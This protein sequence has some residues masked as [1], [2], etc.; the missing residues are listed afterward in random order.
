MKEAFIHI[1]AHKTASTFLQA[2]LNTHKQ[3]LLEEQ[4]LGLLT[5]A[6]LLPSEFGKEIYS[7]S[8]GE[9]PDTDVTD[10]ARKSLRALLPVTDENLLITNED[11]ICH[12]EIRDF[13]QHAESAIR[14]LRTALCDFDCH[15]IMYIRK[16]TDYFESTY[17][18][19][20]H[21][22]RRLKFGQ[23]MKRAA[24]VD[25]SW[26]RVAEAIDRA[27]PPGRLHL[28]TY[29]QIKHIGESNFYR[30][31]LSLCKIDDAE[32]YD[33]DREYAKGRPANRSYGQLGMQIAHRVNPLL[34]PKER[35]VFR[36][37]LQEH[38]STAT[39]P[40]A[41]LLNEEQRQEMED[42]YRVSNRQLFER[43][44]FGIDGRSLGYF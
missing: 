22:G 18:Q 23:F 34:S 7:V 40:R 9:H 37:F 1:G 30:E 32:S 19:L 13:Y 24:D 27:L 16:Q 38:F 21:L 44:D 17:M 26:L 28:R 42:R 43:Y 14:Y 41:E 39:H 25:L 11:L 6:D 29:E 20:V 3:R 2:N 31:F 4:G 12:L 10:A 5:R 33:I 36:R 15:V 35:K 8:Q